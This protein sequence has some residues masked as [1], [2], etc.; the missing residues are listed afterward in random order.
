MTNGQLTSE[1]GA[2]A[3]TARADR[4]TAH[5]PESPGCAVSPD[6][7]VASGARVALPDGRHAWE[8]PASAVS[9]F[10]DLATTVAAQVL[11]QASVVASVCHGDVP[12]AGTLSVT[13]LRHPG[14][15]AVQVHCRSEDTTSVVVNAAGFALLCEAVVSSGEEIPEPVVA[16]TATSTVVEELPEVVDILGDRWDPTGSQTID[17]RLTLIVAESM[18]YAAED[19][20]AE[21]PLIELGLDSLMA[22]RIKNRVEYEFDIPQLQLA[23][24]KDAS[25]HDVAQYLRY[26]VENRDEVAA[27]AAKQ[28]LEREDVQV[29]APEP[30]AEDVPAG[31]GDIDV[32]PRDA[33]ERLAFA[34][35]AVVTGRS[36]KSIF[37]TLPIL[38]D[39]TAEKLAAR[40]TERAGG[41]ITVDDVLDAETIEQLA[42][43]VRRHLEDGLRIDGLVRTLRP[44]VEGSNAVPVFVF[45]PAGGST[46]AYEPL[47][48]RLPAHTPM[49]G[50]ERVEGPLEVRAEEYVPLLRKIQGDGPFVLYGWSFGGALAYAVAKR[51]RQE[52]ADVRIVG[53]IDTVLPGEKVEDTPEEVKARWQRYAA[54]AKKTYN[55][56]AP[57]PYD[58]LAAAGSDEEQIKILMD[59]LRMS[60]AKIPAGIIEHQRTS[61]LDNR[62]IP[63]TDLDEA[64]DGNVVL[65]MAET[66]L[67]DQIALE[68]AFGTRRPDGGWGGAVKNLEIVHVGCDHIQIVDEPYIA[69]VGADLTNKLAA[70]E[71]TSSIR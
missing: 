11:P 21:I 66:Y 45:H 29:A 65:Y 1:D 68:P 27:L 47:L 23:A 69:T 62:A 36:A 17:D 43:S 61:W 46:V 52:G 24:V 13:M 28:Q 18:G 51:L 59:L 38:D 58:Q 3:G 60:G 4:G 22:V 25:L 48:K 40:L 16:V 55:V 49:F 41:D 12:S 63:A 34:T 9:D 10:E 35:W 39:V 20:P 6:R 19:L 5:A 42:E 50:L 44:R 15:A 57:L 32:P 70:I 54:F 64:Y 33:A 37:A 56:D 26:A 7:A 2:Q 67:D 8:L 31:S 30:V 71:G 53:L 14:G